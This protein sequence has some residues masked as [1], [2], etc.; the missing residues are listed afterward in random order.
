MADYYGFSES[1]MK[2]QRAYDAQEPKDDFTIDDL[3]DLQGFEGCDGCEYYEVKIYEW[4]TDIP[5]RP[6]GREK[7]E[8]CNC[9]DESEC[10]RMEEI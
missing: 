2:A 8:Y 3:L 10:K 5:S 6:K 1:F 7:E 9:D 4:T